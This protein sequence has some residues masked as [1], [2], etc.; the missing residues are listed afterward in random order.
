MACVL[1]QY[2]T[3]LPPRECRHSKSST[4]GLRDGRK[5]A[6]PR[7]EIESVD[8]SH[9]IMGVQIEGI[10]RS[11]PIRQDG[12]VMEEHQHEKHQCK[13]FATAVFAWCRKCKLSGEHGQLDI[14]ARFCMLFGRL[15][16]TRSCIQQLDCK[17]TIA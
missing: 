3:V 17:L 7:A 9:G 10:S 8:L 1:D 13:T 5:T 2:R 16:S 4:P 11:N 6:C 14:P 12:E 15:V